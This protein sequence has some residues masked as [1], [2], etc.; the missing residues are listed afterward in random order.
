MVSVTSVGHDFPRGYVDPIYG[1]I[2]WKDCHESVIG[3]S[4]ST[5]HHNDAV[6]ICAPGYHVPTTMGFNINSTK[7][8]HAWGT[9][10]AAP[11]VASAFSLVLSINPCLT[12]DEAIDIVLTSADSGIYLIPENSK[13]IGLLG[14]GRLDVFAA[15]QK[16]V[17][18]ATLK[19]LTPMIFNQGNLSYNSNYA[20]KTIASIVKIPSGSDVTFRARNEI[21]LNSGFEVQLGGAFTGIIDPNS[22]VYC[23]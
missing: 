14:A 22:V 16:A 21:E 1:K 18:T 2:F 19:F 17:E 20:I 7:Y 12:A 23:K 10:F 9:S 5:H 4:S 11:Q 15:A 3:D 6:D 8:S 13:Y